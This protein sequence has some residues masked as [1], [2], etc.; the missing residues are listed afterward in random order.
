[1]ANTFIIEIRSKGFGPAK[2]NTKALKGSIAKLRQEVTKH[3]KALEQA[4]IG[5]KSFEKAQKDLEASTKKLEVGLG[6]VTRKVAGYNKEANG[7][8]GVTSGLRRTIGAL[9]NNLLLI[10]FTLGAVVAGLKKFVDAAA[11]FEAVKT[12]LV[13]LT[14]SV[15]AANKAFDTFNKIAATT[16]FT[17]QDV[18]EAGA[19]LKAFGADAEALIKPI[20]DL[21]AFMGT[22]AVEA[23]NAFGRAFSSGAGAADILRERGILNIVKS[24]QGLT[25]LANTTLPEFRRALIAT[26]QDP[27]VG[28]IGSTDRLSKTYVGAWS[29]MM[30]AMTRASAAIGDLMIPSFT[31]LSKSIG[32]TANTVTDFFKRFNETAFE[33]AIRQVKEMGVAFKGLDL[34]EAKISITDINDNLKE[35]EETIT[36]RVNKSLAGFTSGWSGLKHMSDEAINVREALGGI[37]QF[38]GNFERLGQVADTEMKKVVAAITPL[39]ELEETT[40]AQTAAI[41]ELGVEYQRWAEIAALVAQRESLFEDRVDSVKE[42]RH[43]LGLLSGEVVE[44]PHTIVPA[45]APDAITDMDS[46][47]ND[48][49]RNREDREGKSMKTH[50]DFMLPFWEDIDDELMLPEFDVKD[51]LPPDELSIEWKLYWHEQE[52]QGLAQADR[53]RDTSRQIANDDMKRLEKGQKDLTRASDETARALGHVGSA[54]IGLFAKMKSGKAGMGDFLAAFGSI[55]SM[56][57]GG[58]M[59]G[60]G[61]SIF[62]QALNVATA[63]KG[64]LVTPNGIQRFAAGGSIRG[65][66]NVPILAQGGEFVMNR[67]AVSNIGLDR[68]TDMNRMGSSGSNVTV[69]ISGGVVQDDYVRNELIPALNKATGLGSRIDA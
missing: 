61:M 41:D 47:L 38:D 20:S 17:L 44:I 11:G 54:V 18:V 57:P 30:D 46:R 58:G 52:K 36:E 37:S 14:G 15:K 53:W 67:G 51:L 21:A 49:M 62:G 69:N 33:S 12:R 9:R 39:L 45:W 2:S 48:M 28:I 10:S 5:S 29:N 60:A 68:L 27:V 40:D 42:L 1:M 24:S 4:K 22:T 3:K 31:E 19:Q 64:G 35:L 8:R 65:G 55:I 32:D 6:K 7:M 59:A 56:V 16:P 13:G 25:D 63:H 66:D 23:A 50:S 43:Q 26:L 34:A